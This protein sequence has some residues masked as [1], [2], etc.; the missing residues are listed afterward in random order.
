M[1]KNLIYHSGTRHIEIEH[2]FIRK[3]M[4][5]GSIQIAYCSKN[6]QLVDMFTNFFF[7][8]KFKYFKQMIDF[9]NFC[10]I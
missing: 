10:I 6:D 2:H 9:V 8:V 5:K 3:F 4:V 7:F 1:T